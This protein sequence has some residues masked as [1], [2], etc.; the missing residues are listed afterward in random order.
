VLE[1]S[2]R[3]YALAARVLGVDRS[4]V[5]RKARTSRD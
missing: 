5:R 3:N 2:A 1:K 4:T